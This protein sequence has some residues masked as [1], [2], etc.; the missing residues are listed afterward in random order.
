[1]TLLRDMTALIFLFAIT[2]C[3]PTS[4]VTTPPNR[5]E[6]VLGEYHKLKWL[7]VDVLQTQTLPKDT[8]IIYPD[9]AVT[10]DYSTD[11]LNFQIGK[12]NRIERIFCG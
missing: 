2:G 10:M 11:R 12:T 3:Q 8:R 1:M 4:P 7:P 5:M 6:C 9:T